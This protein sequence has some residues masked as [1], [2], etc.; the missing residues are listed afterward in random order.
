MR[1]FLRAASVILATISCSSAHAI[2]VASGAANDSPPTVISDPGFNNVGPIANSNGGSG[3]YLGN[4]W[5]LTALH[6]NAGPITL[7]NTSY[8]VDTSVAPV[9]FGTGVDLVLFKIVGTPSLPSLEIASQQPVVG[10]TTVMISAGFSA[11]GNGI[12]YYHRTVPQNGDPYYT[13]Q[14]SGPSSPTMDDTAGVKV[15][16]TLTTHWGTNVISRATMSQFDTTFDDSVYTGTSPTAYESQ[17]ALFDSGGAAFVNGRLA[18]VIVTGFRPNGN[19]PVLGYTAQFG[20]GSGMKTISQFRQTIISTTGLG[21]LGDTNGD[22]AVNQTD[23]DNVRNSFG[24][25]FTTPLHADLN[26]NGVVDFGDYQVLQAHWSESVTPFV[27]DLNGDGQVGFGDF[28]IFLSNYNQSGQNLPGDLN[29]DGVV[30]FGDF[31]VLQSDWG[32][33]IPI[34]DLNYDFT[35]GFGDYQILQNEYGLRAMTLNELE[36]DTNGD[37]VVDQTDLDNVYNNWTSQIQPV[38]EPST[39]ALLAIGG[40]LLHRMRRRPI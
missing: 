30:N 4:S 32:K 14:Q 38:P 26:H 2:V 20:I 37:G 18:G 7:L 31:Q 28:Q 8:S 35:V 33:S 40:I 11:D 23:L 21:H 3:I 39:F 16:T 1:F 15:T 29:A 22:G 9:T 34:G 36:G 19:D 6:V 12:R 27:S 25:Q 10:E 17:A 5:V 13:E 24:E